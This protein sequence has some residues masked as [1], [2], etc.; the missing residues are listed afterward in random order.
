MNLYNLVLTNHLAIICLTETWLM[1]HI[2]KPALFL[3]NF[4]IYRKDRPSEN[5]NS[6]HGCSLM[7]ITRTLPSFEITS[8][9]N[10]CVLNL[11][12]PRTL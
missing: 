10:E 4:S 8:D 9:F 1:E 2:S 6:K 11:I 7:T 12:K 3:P 5:G